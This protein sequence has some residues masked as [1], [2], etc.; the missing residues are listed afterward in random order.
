MTRT[1]ANR[2]RIQYKKFKVD[3]PSILSGKHAT[4]SGYFG[5]SLLAEPY[6]VTK[7]NHKNIIRWLY[8]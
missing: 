1:V 4:I 5:G 7:I 6:R 3:P 2:Y 8:T